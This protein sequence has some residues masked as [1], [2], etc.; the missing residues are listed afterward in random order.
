MQLFDPHN[1]NEKKKM[2]VAAVLGLAAIILLGYV[3]FGGS[4]KKTPPRAGGN[5]TP[6]PLRTIANARQIIDEP[7]DDVATLQPISYTPPVP[8][9]SEGDRNIF[10]YYVPPPT[11]V[12]PPPSPTPTPTPPV[13]VSSLS[14]SSVYGRTGDF[15]L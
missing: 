5:P 9:G 1:P 15:S 8:G 6:T 14:P 13:M 10:A 2:I 4:S 11:P 7:I 12:K 3:F